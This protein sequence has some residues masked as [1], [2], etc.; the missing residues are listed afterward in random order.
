MKKQKTDAPKIAIR[1]HRCSTQEQNLMA[2][3]QTTLA[4]CQE[5]EFAILDGEFDDQGFSGK[6]I[7]RP[8]LKRALDALAS[9]RANVLVC[10]KLDRLSRSVPDF[11]SLME[12]A[13]TQGWD[14]CVCDLSI[15]TS[16][17]NGE[18]VA[19][20]IISISQWERRMIGLRTKEMLAAKKRSK[21]KLGRP[22]VVEDEVLDYIIRLR[23]F[24]MSYR[25]IAADLDES[26]IKTPEGGDK[27]NDTSVRLMYLNSQKVVET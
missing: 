1:Y 2:Q 22:Q 7:E 4:K 27:W 13:K 16:T 14:V 3:Q 18:L 21:Q 12:R 6:N 19:N 23:E 9:G 5:R 25:K 10:A 24:G 8:G 20:L 11:G 15:D 17:P 26:G